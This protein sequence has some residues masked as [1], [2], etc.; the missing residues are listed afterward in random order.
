MADIEDRTVTTE[1][2]TETVPVQDTRTSGSR[3]LVNI[4]Y[5][6]EAVI[7]TLLGLR[8]IFR[9]LGANPNNGFADFIYTASHPLVAPFFGLF[10][11]DENLA[12]GHFEVATLVA[13]V[14]YALIA[15]LLVKL[16]TIGRR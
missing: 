3:V 16:V 13:M 1:R 8:F 10:N 9:L 7:L 6:I 11:Y 14:V 4:I 15:W 2:T 5:F 12:S